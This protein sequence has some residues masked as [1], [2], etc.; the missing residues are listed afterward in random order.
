VKEGNFVEVPLSVKN[1]FDVAGVTTLAGSLINQ[2]NLP[3]STDAVLIKRLEAA[4]AW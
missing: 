2:A 4:G 1:L 3:A